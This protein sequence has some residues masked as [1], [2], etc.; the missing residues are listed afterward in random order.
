MLG[1][2][3]TVAQAQLSDFP[4]FFERH[5]SARA[6][7]TQSGPLLNSQF[8]YSA[9]NTLVT[10]NLTKMNRDGFEN[11]M[12]LGIV[13]KIGTARA[14]ITYSLHQ[15]NYASVENH[16]NDITFDFNY[17]SL[18]LQHRLDATKQVST[19][20][21]PIDLNMAHI[22]ISVSQSLQKDTAET[23]DTYKFISQV[24]RLKF[25]ATWMKETGDRIWADYSTEY[26]PSTCWVMKY[27]Y[28]EHGIGLNRQFRSEFAGQGYR[29]A[30]EYELQS[31]EGEQAHTTGAIG[32]EKEMKLAALKLRIEFDNN[33]DSP[34]L[35][36]KVESHTTF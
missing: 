27:S 8:R 18:Y 20:G 4:E 6:T 32:I 34:S 29:L 21:L 1:G 10:T 16:F 28:S 31:V 7:D 36:F 22:G 19:I 30:G 9:G 17:R 25:T 35:Y 5:F 11:H 24:T 33:V 15:F 26:R 23:I 12:A 2:M 13:Q 14:K 3:S